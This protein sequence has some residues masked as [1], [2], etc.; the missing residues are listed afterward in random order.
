VCVNAS[1]A[2]QATPNPPAPGSARRAGDAV[3]VRMTPGDGLNR[4]EGA[5]AQEDPGAFRAECTSDGTA[6]RPS[7][8]VDDGNF[9]L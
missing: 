1:I 5:T 8:A 4:S 9:V 6:H 3:S 2:A 7:R